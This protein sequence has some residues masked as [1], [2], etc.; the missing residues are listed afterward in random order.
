MI[1]TIRPDRKDEL[2]QGL[3]GCRDGESRFGCAVAEAMARHGHKVNLIVDRFRWGIMKPVNNIKI[4][5]S[6]KLSSLQSDIFLDTNWGF[7]RGSAISHITLFQVWSQVSRHVYDTIVKYTESK[8]IVIYPYPH[9]SFSNFSNFDVINVPFPYFDKLK[10]PNFKNNIL[11]YI[12]KGNDKNEIIKWKNIAEK[13]NLRFVKIRLGINW[14]E[15][16]ALEKIRL[17]VDALFAMFSKSKLVICNNYP[18]GIPIESIVNGAAVISDGNI[19][20][21]E[22]F[23]LDILNDEQSYIDWVVEK[24]EKYKMYSFDNFVREIES[25]Y[26]KNKNII[27]T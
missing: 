15:R 2:L 18:T 26:T 20:W 6:S 21:N 22:A 23:Y 1:I 17:P 3:Y 25:L 9:V 19:L 8:P 11:L 7:L 13:D 27:T 16:D 14:E 4:Y 10:S 24:Q 5:D 12:S